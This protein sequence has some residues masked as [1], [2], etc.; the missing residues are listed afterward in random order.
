M[1]FPKPARLPDRMDIPGFD[2]KYYVCIDGTVWHRWKTTDTRLYGHQRGHSRQLKLTDSEGKVHL[3]TFS[4][5]MR[6]TYFAGIDQSQALMHQNG[7]KSDWSVQNLQVVDRSTLGR[8]RNRHK[9]ARS[10]LKCDPA[11]LE[12]IEVYKSARDAGRENFMSYQT[13][14]D[15]CNLKNKKRKGIAPDGFAYRWEGRKYDTR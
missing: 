12:A 7:I 6:H 13:V 2:G 3:K 10:V 4:W 15:C 1:I 9:R 5:V 11:T 14:L 8:K